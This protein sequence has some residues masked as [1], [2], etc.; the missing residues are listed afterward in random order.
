MNRFALFIGCWLLLLTAQGKPCPQLTGLLREG[1]AFMREQQ[2]QKALNKFN[3]AKLCQPDRS[4]EIDKRIGAVFDAIENKKNEAIRQKKRADSARE[5]AQQSEKAAHDATFRAQA[6]Y[7]ASESDKL[8]PTQAIRLLEQAGRYNLRVAPVYERIFRRFNESDSLLLNSLDLPHR[9]FV[10]SAVFSP[11]G[12]RILTASDDS[13]ATVWDQRGDR[14][15]TCLLYT[16]PSP[17]DS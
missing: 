6:L 17:R 1:N 15:L 10:N 16:S 11:D 14:L 5:A 9:G 4:F 3:A 12:S 2:F 7:W 13:T 8:P